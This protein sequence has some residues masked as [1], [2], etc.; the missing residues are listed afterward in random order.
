M[1]E[2]VREVAD[3]YRAADE[4]FGGQGATEHAERADELEAWADELDGFEPDVEQ[5][6]VD[7]EALEDKMRADGFTEADEAEWTSVRQ[8]RYDEAE[9]A[10]DDAEALEQAREQALEAIGGCPL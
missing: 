9:E 1:A 7:E 3:E 4:E 10:L 8:E 2:A 6:Q 5:P